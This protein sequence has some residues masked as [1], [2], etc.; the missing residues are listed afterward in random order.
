MGSSEFKEDLIREK[1]LQYIFVYW[2]LRC[3]PVFMRFMNPWMCWLTSHLQRVY[4]FLYKAWFKR[5]VHAEKSVFWYIVYILGW[6]VVVSQLRAGLDVCSF[7]QLTPIRDK[8]AF[9]VSFNSLTKQFSII[10]NTHMLREASA[11]VLAI[12]LSSY[13]NL[14]NLQQACKPRSYA[15][16]KLRVTDWREWSVELVA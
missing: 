13:V 10:G 16:S 11:N 3:F 12:F 1:S 5:C 7:L 8:T 9:F 4:T 14:V 15:S 2:A 6:E